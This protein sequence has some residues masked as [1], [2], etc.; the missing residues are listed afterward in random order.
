[1][2]ILKRRIHDLR[3]D[4][5]MKQSDV[6]DALNVSQSVISAYECGREPPLDIIFKYADFFGVSVGYLIGLTN[7]K[8]G[9]VSGHEKA[10]DEMQSGALANGDI[11][12]SRSDIS[13]LAASFVNYYKAGAPAGSIP[14][15]CTVA[16]LGAMTRLLDAAAQRD[17][18]AVMIAGD[19]AARAGMDTSHALA[20][21]L[22]VRPDDD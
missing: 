7:D 11:A 14:M 9:A 6:A 10:I 19:D 21:V 12:F 3:V 16:F 13:Q 22:G 4:S 17:A 18:A 20:A 2:D 15:A 8:S 5:D 1:M